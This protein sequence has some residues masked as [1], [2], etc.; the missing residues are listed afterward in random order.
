VNHSDSNSKPYLLGKFIG[1][2]PP[3]LESKSGSSILHRLTCIGLFKKST[4]TS[5]FNTTSV[6]DVLSKGNKLFFQSIIHF[7]KL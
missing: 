1:L 4:S 7:S 6:I 2:N 3:I 5:V